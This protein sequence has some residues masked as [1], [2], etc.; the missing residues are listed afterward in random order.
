MRTLALAA[1]AA[2]ALV[3]SLPRPATAQA[4]RLRHLASVYADDTGVGLKRPEG[5]A[6]GAGGMI[7]VA[8]TGNG[9]LLRFTYRERTVSGGGEIRIPELS[10]PSRLHLG[11]KGQ[12]YVL[13]STRRRIVR[14][15]PDGEFVGA[16]SFDGAPPPGTI[17]P[18]S[19]AVDAADRAYVLDAFAGRVLVLD[20]QGRFERA[21][22]LPADA[23]FVTDVAVD[24]AG[25]LVLLDSV[26]RQLYAIGDAGAFA[27]LGRDLK[28]AL[29]TPPTSLTMGRGL[30]FILE[31]RG[32]RVVTVGRDGS[33]LSSQLARGWTEGMLNYPSQMCIN[34]RDEVFVAD[35][36]NSRIQVFG[37]TR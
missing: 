13:D 23:G 9:R 31:G 22:P 17:V 12:I 4:A 5:I 20:G 37:L 1:L 30:I 19:F 24:T 11:S 18:K 33:F 7:V 14:L 15:G 35:R 3:T 6:C 8:D 34:D 21:L 2:A 28:E 29:P 27:P 16:L 32:G 25:S 36:D 26:R 10:A